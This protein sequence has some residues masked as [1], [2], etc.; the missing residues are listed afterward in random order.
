[1]KRLTCRWLGGRGSLLGLRRDIRLV[2]IVESLR[3]DV[4][5]LVV[6]CDGSKRNSMGVR[7]KLPIM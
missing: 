4:K 2:Y 5:V 1:M 3:R 6:S 7:W